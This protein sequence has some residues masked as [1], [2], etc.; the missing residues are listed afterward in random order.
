[1][2]DSPK[3]TTA[4]AALVAGS[5]CTVYVTFA[6]SAGGS[7]SGLLTVTDDSGNL[8]ATQTVTLSR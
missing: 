4:L 5:N 2:A 8:G 7:V 3:Q 6:P 1:M